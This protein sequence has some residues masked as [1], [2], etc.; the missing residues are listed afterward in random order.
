MKARVA[1]LLPTTLRVSDGG[2]SV[3]QMKIGNPAVHCT[4]LFASFRCSCDERVLLGVLDP[5]QIQVHV[6]LRPIQVILM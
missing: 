5:V 2:P 3:S 1:T 6:Q 4:R